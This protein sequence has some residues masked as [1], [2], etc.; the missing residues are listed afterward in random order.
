MG[1]WGVSSETPAASW[2]EV[3]VLLVIFKRTMTDR[4]DS[5]NQNCSQTEAVS[6]GS[7]PAGTGRLPEIYIVCAPKQTLHPSSCRRYNGFVRS[8]YHVSGFAKKGD[9]RKKKTSEERK[10]K[11]GNG[12]LVSDNESAQGSRV[13]AAL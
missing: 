1:G 9:V 4:H 12:A 13:S 2:I 10:R 6:W 3:C 7:G 8:A 11:K 5:G